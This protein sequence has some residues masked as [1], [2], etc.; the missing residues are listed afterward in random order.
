VGSTFG[1]YVSLGVTLQNG[2]LASVPRSQDDWQELFQPQEGAVVAAVGNLGAQKDAE[3]KLQQYVESTHP[4]VF[5]YLGEVHEFGSWATTLDHYGLA[6]YDDPLGVGS[7]WGRMASYTLPTPGNHQRGYIT[8]FQ[9]YWHQRPLW[10]TISLDGVRIYDLTSECG[11][12]G[13]CGTNGAQAQ[14]LQ[15]QLVANAEPCVVAMW[16]RPVVSMD[17]DRSG[18]TMATVWQ[19]LAAGGGDVILNADTRD[20]EELRPMNV[21]MQAGR[22]DSHMVEL[23]S[24]AGAARWVMSASND[25]RVAWELYKTPGAVWVWR[26]GTLAQPRLNWEFRSSKGAVLRTGSVACGS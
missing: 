21:A 13:G 17:R 10:S 22:P 9:D 25:K 3:L 11:A 12:N 26:A 5:A 15:E 18:T 16:H 14:W 7:M 4:A 23:I 20:M 8:E 19:L 24:G 2:N 6:S 1:A